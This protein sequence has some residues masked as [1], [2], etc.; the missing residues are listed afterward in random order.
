[1]FAYELQQARRDDLQHRAD[2]WRLARDA[3]AA[4]DAARGNRRTTRTAA[5]TAARTDSAA[6]PAAEAPA[7]PRPSVANL[8]RITFSHIDTPTA[9]DKTALRKAVDRYAGLSGDAA[10]Y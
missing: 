1:M 6:D 9:T 10:R 2:A 4:R 5:R 3:K 7:S 8:G